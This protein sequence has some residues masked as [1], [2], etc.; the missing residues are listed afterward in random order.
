MKGLLIGGCIVVAG[1]FVGLVACKMVNKNPKLLKNT[2]KT[3]F[4]IG[5][6]TSEAVAEAKRAFSEGFKGAQVKVAT[7]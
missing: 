7:A 1:V 4:D 6:K 2:K 5:K 3:L